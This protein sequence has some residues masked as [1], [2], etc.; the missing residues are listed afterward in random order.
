MGRLG[1]IGWP[2]NQSYSQEIHEQLT[3]ASYELIPLRDKDF[4]AFMR[5]AD[6]QG[7]NVTL[8]YKERVIP[9]LDV[10]DPVA[11]AV[12]AVNTIVRVDGQL[13]GYNTD[14]FGFQIMAREAAI[15]LAGKKVLICGSGG[16]SRT[17]A[18]AAR[19]MGDREVHRLS[20]TGRQGAI[21]YEEAYAHHGDAEI[22]VNA[23]PVGMFPRAM[24]DV[25]IDLWEFPHLEGVLDIVYNPLRS[26][27]TLEAEKRSLPSASGLSMLVSQAYL[28]AR[29]FT[30][31]DLDSSLA[32]QVYLDLLESK[33]NIVLTGMPSCGKSSVGKILNKLTGRPLYDTDV[34]FKQKTGHSVYDYMQKH[35]E[36]EF[37][38]LETQ[39]I[40][41]LRGKTGCIISTGGGSVI[42]EENRDALKANGLLFFIKRP[43]YELHPTASR[44]LASDRASMSKRYQERKNIYT[45]ADITINA[46]GRGSGAVAREIA[47][48]WCPS[49]YR[50]GA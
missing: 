30:D 50:T 44:P 16:S 26:Q 37:R 21:R 47:A 41:G 29:L 32:N 4:D 39:I 25:P 5:T 49:E 31:A 9:Y 38:D 23:T 1:L 19:S 42:R 24:E 36:E 12:G 7:L 33:R 45:K 3:G 28:S 20:R 11:Q 2:L 13:H 43:L 22:V 40:R 27:L 48:K 6:F 8:P 15:D 35:S 34:L 10:L 46:K 14:F 17:V 18:A